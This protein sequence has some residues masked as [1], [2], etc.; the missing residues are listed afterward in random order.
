LRALAG[1]LIGVGAGLFGCHAEVRGT[2]GGPGGASSP[3][4]QAWKMIAERD[5][6]AW[7]GLPDVCEYHQLDSAFGAVE[8]T[9]GQFHLGRNGVPT[10]FRGHTAKGYPDNFT[11]WVRGD[12][13]VLINAPHPSLPYATSELLAHLGT[14]EMIRDY[15]LGVVD[16]VHEGAWIY[17]TRGLALFLEAPAGPDSNVARVCLFHACSASEYLDLIDP[18]ARVE[19][20]APVPLP[21]PPPPAAAGDAG[22][23]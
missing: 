22:T 8:E 9:H 12:H 20:P 10:R 6:R 13:I 23:I 5:F 19:K 2:G 4:A 17:S 15:Q 3:C 11:V 16:A 7:N 1:V 18:D 21:P 14:P